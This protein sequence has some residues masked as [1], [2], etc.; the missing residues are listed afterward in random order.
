MFVL[1]KKLK[2]E[3]TEH[4]LS[5]HFVD[6]VAISHKLIE[7]F[8]QKYGTHI[9][10]MTA[11]LGF[12]TKNNFIGQPLAGYDFPDAVNIDFEK[13]DIRSH[14]ETT[15]EHL[16]HNEKMQN[17]PYFAL[18][19]KPMLH[20]LVALHI[21]LYQTQGWCFNLYD[22]LRFKDTIKRDQVSNPDNISFD[23]FIEQNDLNETP[24]PLAQ[25]ERYLP[26]LTSLRDLI[27][28]GYLM[29]PTRAT[30]K[31][32]YHCRGDAVDGTLFNIKTGKPV[33][34]LSPISFMHPLSGWGPSQLGSFEPSSIY[35]EKDYFKFF[36][37]LAQQNMLGSIADFYEQC[38]QK[39][40]S[41]ANLDNII[42][43]GISNREKFK[44][45]FEQFGFFPWATENWHLTLRD[46][47]YNS[48]DLEILS[49]LRED[50]LVGEH[51]SDYFGLNATNEY[52]IETY[53]LVVDLLLTIPDFYQ[54]KHSKMMAFLS[55]NLSFFNELKMIIYRTIAIRMQI[56]NTS[57][58]NDL[59]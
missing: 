34:V 23:E 10:P 20:R 54:Y 3:R 43:E 5:Q 48:S 25:K 51:S 38:T 35:S 2:N 31:W 42:K 41:I 36:E 7:L 45:A 59:A 32:S 40:F 4:F 1:E 53:P 44:V 19:A 57:M 27:T 13:I 21:Y 17:L 49:L 50:P 29:V 15:V 6:V 12:A 11:C 28:N 33:W 37:A 18:V 58:I 47:C 39:K 30:D 56:F 46:E 22:T 9:P 8:N 14:I 16:R 24:I 55:K 52:A 26:N